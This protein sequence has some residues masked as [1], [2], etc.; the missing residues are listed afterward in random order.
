M[1][2]VVRQCIMETVR[3]TNI[4]PYEN[5]IETRG[6][7]LKMFN[8]FSINFSTDFNILFEIFRCTM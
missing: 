4:K 2:F 6:I 3:N 8:V 7:Y 5:S 1:I